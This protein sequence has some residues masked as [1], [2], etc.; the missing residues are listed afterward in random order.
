[1]STNIITTTTTTIHTMST[2]IHIQIPVHGLVVSPL[3]TASEQVRFASTPA[4]DVTGP[5][6]P[7]APPCGASAN[8]NSNS[9]NINI[10]KSNKIKIGAIV[11]RSTAD[12]PPTGFTGAPGSST[13]LRT[14]T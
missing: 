14:R 4:S 3:P 11:S 10:N 6:T 8:N 12:C 2:D 9:N 1:M 13:S 5:P 7:V